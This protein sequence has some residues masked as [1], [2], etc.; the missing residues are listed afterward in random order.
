MLLLFAESH[1]HSFGACLILKS[2]YTPD[3]STDKNKHLVK[4][5]LLNQSTTIR[6][7]PLLIGLTGKRPAILT[8]VVNSDQLNWFYSLSGG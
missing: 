4:V 5:I 8:S 7:L 6:I 1:K 3:Q 2:Q